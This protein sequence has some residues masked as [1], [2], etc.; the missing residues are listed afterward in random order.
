MVA[1]VPDWPQWVPDLICWGRTEHPL[2]PSACWIQ[3]LFWPV[4]GCTVCC[5]CSGTHAACGVCPGPAGVGAEL[6]SHPG[7]AEVGAACSTVPQ[8]WDGWSGCWIQPVGGG[9]EALPGCS[10]G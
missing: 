5:T 6:G 10:A 2:D 4:W 3:C 7:L 8:S 9:G 1:Q